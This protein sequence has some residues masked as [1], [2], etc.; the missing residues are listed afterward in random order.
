MYSSVFQNSKCYCIIHF[1]SIKTQVLLFFG[2][3]VSR[4][5][6][7]SC[8][9]RFCLNTREALACEHKLFKVTNSVSPVCHGFKDVVTPVHI[10]LHKFYT[11]SSPHADIQMFKT[12]MFSSPRQKYFQI[13][14]NFLHA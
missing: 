2:Y 12:R 14:W 7:T 13:F 3:G 10:P 6:N 1:W 8:F 5:K 4:E 11:C 9:G